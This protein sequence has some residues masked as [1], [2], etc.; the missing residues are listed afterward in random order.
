METN[1]RS[2]KTQIQG[3][4]RQKTQKRVG[5]VEGETERGAAEPVEEHRRKEANR[6]R[7]HDI[8]QKMTEVHENTQTLLRTA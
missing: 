3:E 6:T 8:V 1:E 7:K 2:K 4:K 5:L